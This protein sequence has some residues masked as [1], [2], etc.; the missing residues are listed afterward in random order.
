MADENENLTKVT[1][2]FKVPKRNLNIG[3][4]DKKNR[5][6]NTRFNRPIKKS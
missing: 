5:P 6:F 4:I 3:G 2:S 1:N